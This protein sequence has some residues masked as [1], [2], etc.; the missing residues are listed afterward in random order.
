MSDANAVEESS[1]TCR[2]AATSLVISRRGTYA[3]ADLM[4]IDSSILSNAA[5]GSSARR[6]G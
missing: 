6:E 1:M 4:V 3:V 5:G 2:S